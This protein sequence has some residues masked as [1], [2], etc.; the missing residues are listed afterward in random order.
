MRVIRSCVLST[1]HCLQQMKQRNSVCNC[2]VTLCGNRCQHGSFSG[3]FW[4]EKDSDTFYRLYAWYMVR[5]I[6]FDG[7]A[8]IRSCQSAAARF[9]LNLS[10]MLA[11]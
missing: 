5:V 11:C 1:T 7:G 6:W 2:S 4:Q 10:Q 9:A 3:V 8:P